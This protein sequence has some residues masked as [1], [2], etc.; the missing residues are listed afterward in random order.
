MLEVISFLADCS[1]SQHNRHPGDTVCWTPRVYFGRKRW[2]RRVFM[3]SLGHEP[4]QV[5]PGD[6]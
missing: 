6:P 5:L 4:D 2:A 1:T 3:E